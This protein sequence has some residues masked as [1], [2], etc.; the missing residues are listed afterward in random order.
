MA[1]NHN[2]AETIEDLKRQMDEIRTDLCCP[3]Q[4]ND[5]R[6]GAPEIEIR[7][8]DLQDGIPDMALKYQEIDFS[9]RKMIQEEIDQIRAQI[10]NRPCE[11]I[12]NL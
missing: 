2:M 3:Q 1:S 10:V 5:I 8:R 12:Q 7:F 11:Y 4:Q 9:T 6:A